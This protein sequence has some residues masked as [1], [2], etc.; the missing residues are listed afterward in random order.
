MTEREE[1]REK[2]FNETHKIIYCFD[3][4]H[5]WLEKQILINEE[6]NFKRFM[7]MQKEAIEKY[8]WYRSKEAGKD[9]GNKCC[10][11]WIDN[12]AKDFAKK[13]WEC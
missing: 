6:N 2:F 9:L 3:D 5:K 13:Y 12:F 4:Y 1:L 10:I 7:R 11:E 8:K